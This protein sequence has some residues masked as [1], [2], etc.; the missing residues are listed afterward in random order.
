MSKTIIHTPSPPPPSTERESSAD[1][2]NS[3]SSILHGDS[4]AV[5][6]QFGDCEFDGVITDPPYS[7]GGL[8]LGDRQKSTAAKYTATKN[9]N[10]LPDFEGDTRDQHSW[11]LWMTEWMRE[12]KRATKQGGVICVFTDWR[13]LPATILALQWADWT[14]R[15][16]TVWDKSEGVRPQKGRFR[17]Q[18]EYIIWG[19]KGAMPLNRDAPVLPGVYKFTTMTQDKQHQTEKPLELMRNIVKIVERGG[20]I[21][22]PFCGSGSTVL[23]A[24]LEGYN[25][26]GIEVTTE[27]AAIAYQRIT[28]EY[29]T[30]KQ[31]EQKQAKKQHEQQMQ[32]QPRTTLNQF[33]T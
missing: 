28:S 15:G 20:K 17:N 22:D 8:T 25:A 24:K 4:L 12:A 14:W 21:L 33:L 5:L 32:H 19:S 2:S 11:T 31:H 13:Q 1:V 16:I 26:I 23:A 29:E 6:R 10:P 30:V 3:S 18:A 7:S 27:Y 9:G